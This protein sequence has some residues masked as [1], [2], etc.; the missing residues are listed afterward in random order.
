MRSEFKEYENTSGATLT[1]N[2]EDCGA[3]IQEGET[4]FADNS[5]TVIC[6]DCYE[7]MLALQD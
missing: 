4:F 3:T 7:T 2:V 5:N 6:Q 1:C